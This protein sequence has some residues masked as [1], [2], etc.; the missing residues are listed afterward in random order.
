MELSL[1]ELRKKKLNS[2]LQSPFQ[3]TKFTRTSNIQKII[4]LFSHLPQD[5]LARIEEKV[6]IAGRIM[7]LRNFG[8]LI[9]ADLA[10]QTGIIQ[11]KVSKNKDFAELDS[12]DIIGVKGIICKTNKGELSVEVKEFILL[13]KC[14]KPIPDTSYYGFTD[15]EERFRKRYLDFITNRENRKIFITRHKVI[16]SIR[17][18]LDEQEFIEIE[19]P[20]LVSEASGA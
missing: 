13:S 7:P 10:D 11:L 16:Q 17:K 5:E 15:I 6:S 4:E 20:I 14:L 2:L 3:Q 8:N 9:F 18:F 1:E 19:T 12:G